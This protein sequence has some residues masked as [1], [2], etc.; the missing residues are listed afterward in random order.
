MIS[1]HK[2]A[3]PLVLQICKSASLQIAF[4]CAVA[5]IPLLA[6]AFVF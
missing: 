6:S 4:E 1:I 5:V 3:V 2:R